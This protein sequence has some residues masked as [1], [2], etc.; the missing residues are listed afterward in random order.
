[1]HPSLS[2]FI[3]PVLSL[4]FQKA[5]LEARAHQIRVNAISPGFLLTD[6]TRPLAKTV[7]GVL[8]G[9]WD[10]LEERQGRSAGADEVG[11]VAVLITSPRMGLVNG[12]NLFVD[13]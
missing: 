8:A 6:L 11:D 7:G 3:A 2:L 12:A 1:M 5:A 4:Y 9:M 13:G 10:A